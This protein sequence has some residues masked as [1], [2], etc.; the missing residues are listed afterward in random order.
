MDK[1][2]RENILSGQVAIVTGGATGI[3]Y[4]IAEAYLKFGCK[5]CITSRKKEVLEKSS[6]RLAKETGNRNVLYFP[7]DVRDFKQVESMVQFVIDKWSKVDILINGAAGNFLVPFEL[8]SPNAFRT[9]LEID[10]M[11][12]FHVLKLQELIVLQSSSSQTYV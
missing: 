10:T 2:F 5:V 8:M 12:T 6:E 11:G 1:I 9:V 3:C 7:C 4:G